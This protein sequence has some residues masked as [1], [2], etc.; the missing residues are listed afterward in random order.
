MQTRNLILFVFITPLLKARPREVMLLSC[1]Y[2]GVIPSSGKKGFSATP[3]LQA[4][5]NSP[6]WSTL[7]PPPLFSISES[8]VYFKRSSE[9][10][11]F[12][13]YNMCYWI[14]FP[15]HS[16]MQAVSHLIFPSYFPSVCLY[17]STSS[18]I[19]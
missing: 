10:S 3:P 1:Y 8:S 6:H 7:I 16:S 17:S 2:Y 5:R 13:H 4:N 15:H 18:S 11:M 9:A 14:I 12:L 19:A